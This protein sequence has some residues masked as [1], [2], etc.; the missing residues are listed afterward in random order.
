[1]RSRGL[2]SVE[3]SALAEQAGERPFFVSPVSGSEVD[4]AR[5]VLDARAAGLMRQRGVQGVGISSSADA[6][7]EAALLV[8]VVKGVPRDPIPLV[9]DG[10]RTRVRETGRFRAR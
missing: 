8:F 5:G 1:M 7:G 4:R 3:D 10:L 9:L 6:P 2:L